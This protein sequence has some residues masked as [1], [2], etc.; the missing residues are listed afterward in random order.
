M[1]KYVVDDVLKIDFYKYDKGMDLSHYEGKEEGLLIGYV[2]EL[3][4]PVGANLVYFIP[5]N[6]GLQIAYSSLNDLKF[7]L[8]IDD[9]D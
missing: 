8:K 1:T 4:S 5:F 7:H 2:C 3:V 9:Q 6:M